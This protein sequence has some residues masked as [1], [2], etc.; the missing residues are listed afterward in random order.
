MIA[1]VKGFEKKLIDSDLNRKELAHRIGISPVTL[2]AK[3]EKPDADFKLSEAD[4]IAQIT[5][6]DERE[7]MCIFFGKKLSSNESLATR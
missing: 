1:D 5:K 6:M 3:L 4:K 7:F 2:T